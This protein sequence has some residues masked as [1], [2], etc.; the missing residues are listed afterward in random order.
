MNVRADVGQAMWVARGANI[1][2]SASRRKR[3]EPGGW[4]GCL[5]RG[6]ISA[7][8]IVGNERQWR[9]CSELISPSGARADAGFGRRRLSL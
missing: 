7:D 5:S 9:R 6:A 4:A 2:A 1:W 3:P 8:V